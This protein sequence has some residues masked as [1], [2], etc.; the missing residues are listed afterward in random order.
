MTALDDPLLATKLYVP[1][2][3]PNSVFRERL[4]NRLNIGL[5]HRLTLISAPAGFGKTTLLGDWISKTGKPVSWLSLDSED[6]NPT[7]FLRYLIASLREVDTAV[8][9]QALSRLQF[10]RNADSADIAKILLGE[11]TASG[12]E[13]L[14]VLDDYH[15]INSDQIHQITRKLVDYLPPH[16]HFIILTRMDPPFPIAR[17]RSLGQ[18]LELR[19]MDLAFTTGETAVFLNEMM[20]LNISPVDIKSLEART[21]G[22][23]AG[24]QLAAI[25]LQGCTDATSFIHSFAGDD[26]HI[27]DYLVE[28]VLE[29]QTEEVQRFLFQ[30]SI[31]SHLSES[32]CDSIIGSD[33]SHDI[34]RYLEASNLFLIP[35]DNKRQWFRYHHLFADLLLQRL[36]LT[37]RDAVKTLHLKASVWYERNNHYHDAIRHAMA[38]EDQERAA[39]LIRRFVS[40]DWHYDSRL[41]EWHKQLPE[42]LIREDPELSFFCGWMLWE[43]GRFTD[44]ESFLETAELLTT[45]NLS[46]TAD[47]TDTSSQPGTANPTELQGRITAI[48]ACL[49]HARGHIPETIDLCEQSE[50]YLRQSRSSWIAVPIHMQALAYRALGEIDKAIVKFRESETA[51]RETSD[52]LFI[53]LSAIRPIELL[54]ER[55]NISGAIETFEK[56]SEEAKAAGFSQSP[57]LGWLYCSWGEVL[58]DLRQMN[59]AKVLAQKG[60]ALSLQINESSMIGRTHSVLADILLSMGDTDGARAVVRQVE[61]SQREIDLPLNYQDR[62][63]ML[64]VRI[65]LACGEIEAAADWMKERIRKRSSVFKLDADKEKLLFARICL[66]Q[67]QAANALEHLKPLNESPEMLLLQAR[68]LQ[69]QGQAELSRSKLKHALALTEKSGIINCYVV[70]GQTIADLLQQLLDTDRTAPR[71]YIKK[72]LSAFHLSRFIIEDEEMIERLSDRELEVLRFIEAGLSNRKIAEELYISLSTVKTHLRNIYSKL[73]VNSRTQAT[74][75]AKKLGLL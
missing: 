51:A 11:L 38:A 39:V 29:Q 12:V 70:E 2:P 47:N 56:L 27:V 17:L 67:G 53:L 30:T 41:L 65:W 21:E 35:L 19:A 20:A 23:I 62:M 40:Q 61:E 4:I 42:T 34:L 13:Q 24:L 10:S 9:E 69:E 1:Q 37:G 14:L 32:L 44:A 6:N 66:A 5:S 28:E 49:E 54:R 43:D 60:V 68:I 46:T 63:K 58:A 50:K 64:N 55:G 16:I 3:G 22:W 36:Q 26:R 33:S 45:E 7:Q 25:S 15:V 59:D 52:F 73:D 72:L 8:G 48:R 75:K 74:A 31:L 71:R 57:I 18:L